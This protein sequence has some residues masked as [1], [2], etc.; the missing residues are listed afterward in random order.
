M[1]AEP[2]RV[3]MVCTGNI[4]RSPTAEAVLRAKARAAGMG[5]R[6]EVASAGVSNYHVGEAPDRRTQAHARLRGYDLSALRARQVQARD[7][8]RFD[9]MLAM[10]GGHLR[11]LLAQAPPERLA[12]LR[13]FLDF[14]EGHA[15]QDVPDPY[16][17][18]VAGFEQVLDLVEAASEGFLRHLTDT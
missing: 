9:W 12:Q 17:G 14:A 6:I 7:F 5:G 13:L 16:Y 8:Y 15:G 3:L 11:Q 2:I 18:G 1:T 4:C 10:D